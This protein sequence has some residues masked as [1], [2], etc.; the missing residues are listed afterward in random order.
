M[1]FC[2]HLSDRRLKNFAIEKTWV[3]SEDMC[4]ALCFADDRCLSINFNQTQDP[5]EGTHL[6]ELNNATATERP[7]YLVYGRDIA[8]RGAKVNR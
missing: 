5:G 8:Y 2:P 3:K 4:Q 6:C 7:Q 1:D